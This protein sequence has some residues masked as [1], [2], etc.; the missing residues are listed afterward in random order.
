VSLVASVYDASRAALLGG[1][2]MDKAG[3]A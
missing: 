3:A 2:A 1:L